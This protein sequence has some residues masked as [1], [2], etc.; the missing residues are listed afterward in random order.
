MTG[1][2]VTVLNPYGLLC[3]GLLLLITVRLPSYHMADSGDRG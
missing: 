1:S 3:G 2:Y